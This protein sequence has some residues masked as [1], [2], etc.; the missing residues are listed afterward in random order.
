MSLRFR[1]HI[2]ALE[3]FEA[4]GVFD[5]N[6]DGR[7][8]IVSG[9]YW[10]EQPDIATRHIIGDV[11]AYGEYYDDFSVIPLDVNG[12]GRLDFITGGWWGNT[13]RWRENPGDPTRRGRNTSSRRSATWRPPAPGTWTATGSS[14]SCPTR[15]TAR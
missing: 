5:V 10:Y 2:I 1:K 11:A 12:D 7:P 3:R 13:L 15:P 8:E 4:A 9:A 14:R 6:G